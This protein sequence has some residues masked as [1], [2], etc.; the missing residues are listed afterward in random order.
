M[1]VPLSSRHTITLLCRHAFKILRYCCG[2]VMIPAFETCPHHT[3][4]NMRDVTALYTGYYRCWYGGRNNSH[5]SPLDNPVAMVGRFR[6]D[7]LDPTTCSS[8]MH[9]KACPDCA[10]DNSTSI[11][12]L[13]QVDFATNGGHTTSSVLLAYHS[14]PEGVKEWESGSSQTLRLKASRAWNRCE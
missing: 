2:N 1:K 12:L 9:C 14:Q 7:C 10:S 6:A 11:A 4:N 3:I 8:M 13:D 5:P